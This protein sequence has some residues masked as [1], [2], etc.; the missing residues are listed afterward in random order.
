L[1]EVVAKIWNFLVICATPVSGPVCRLAR[2][3]GR[4]VARQAG[5]L[6]GSS[7]L[8]PGSVGRLAN[9]TRFFFNSIKTLVYM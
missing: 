7:G 3:L 9:S 2:R 4:R 6:T 8:Q 5:C 1:Y